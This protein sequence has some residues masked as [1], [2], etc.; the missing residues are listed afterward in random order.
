MEDFDSRTGRF[1]TT[2]RLFRL[3]AE[4]PKDKQLILLKGLL[5]ERMLTH[6]YQL[7]LDLSEAQQHQLMDQLLEYPLD[8][9]PV[10]TLDLD[11]DD[12]LIRRLN[13]TSCT[14]RAV[15]AV[16]GGTFDAVITDISLE[17]M[18]I[19]TERAYPTGKPIRISCR[20]QGLEKP[21]ILNGLVQRSEPG[22][23][24]VQLKAPNPEQARAIRAFLQV[25]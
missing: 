7:V 5:G 9:S 16:E 3:V 11:G 21:L 13:R 18:F 1:G 12:A 2:E 24:G 23:L 20:L 4:L 22:G 15:C 19:K 6:L 10:T 25:G 14:L 17:G 8:E